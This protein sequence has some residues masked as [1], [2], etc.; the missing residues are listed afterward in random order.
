MPDAGQMSGIPL[1]A[2]ELPN[3]T[4]SVR[5]VRERMGNNIAGHPCR[6]PA[7]GQTW[8]GTTDA[9]GRAEF[10]GFPAGAR[11]VA[12]T[13]V[14][15]ECWSRRSFRAAGA[16]C[17]SRWSPG[18]RRQA[19]R[20]RAAAEAAAQEPARQGMVVLG[21]QSRVILEF[22]NDVLHRLLP[23]RHRQQRAHAHRHRRAARFIVLPQARTGATLLQGSST[24][25]TC[26]AID[27][28]SPAPSRPASHSVQVGF[29]MPYAATTTLTQQWPAAFEQLFVAVEK[30]GNLQISS[31]QFPR[32]RRCR[33][34]RQACS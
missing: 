17:A 20:E 28:A 30:V 3:G 16:A 7:A 10:T 14:D 32:R 19:E 1:P 18:H 34:R 27:D 26:A 4:V 33:R 8:T 13:T 24:Q 25:A 29:S 5:V 6:S 21:G 31:P 15:G 23:A 11:V 9:Q 12:T 2:P 22:Q